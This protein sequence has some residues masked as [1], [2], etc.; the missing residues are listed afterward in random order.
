MNA[1]AIL[2]WHLPASTPCT[3]SCSQ[4]SKALSKALS[5][6]C[7]VVS[8]LVFML[9]SEGQIGLHA[10]I[11]LNVSLWA[12]PRIKSFTEILSR[13]ECEAHSHGMKCQE[14]L[15]V[16]FFQ[17]SLITVHLVTHSGKERRLSE[18]RPVVS[19]MFFSFQL[20]FLPLDTHGNDRELKPEQF[21]RAKTCEAV[22]TR[23]M[24]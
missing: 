16:A 13:T 11:G 1:F 18:V 23:R 7:T 20:P 17:K 9:P 2:D 8:K 21:E 19:F 10:C 5:P 14:H 12:L 24:W 15:Q 22:A 4:N 3:C 6:R